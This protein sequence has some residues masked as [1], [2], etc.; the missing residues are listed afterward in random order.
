MSTKRPDADAKLLFKVSGITV[1]EFNRRL[2]AALAEI[3]TGVS[4]AVKTKLGRKKP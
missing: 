2:S 3:T 4:E 1:E